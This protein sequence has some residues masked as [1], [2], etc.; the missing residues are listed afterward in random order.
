MSTLAL[1]LIIA[2]LILFGVGIFVEALKFLLVIAAIL[3]VAA[4]IVWMIRYI[5]GGTKV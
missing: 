5:R 3:G 4:L 2:A 1:I